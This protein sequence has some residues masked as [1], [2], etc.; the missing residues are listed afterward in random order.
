MSCLQDVSRLVD[1]CRQTVIFR[2]VEGIIACL[3]SI[4]KD[5]DI[6][7]LRIK[8]RLNPEFDARKSAGYRD[9]AL[10]LQIVTEQT[11]ALGIDAHVCELQLMLQSV[12][13]L[14]VSTPLSSLFRCPP[15]TA[16]R[17]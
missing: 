12:A 2:T 14:K 4:A 13:E 15:S 16:L 8:N 5:P 6:K 1:V 17:I 3:A 7:I 11:K 10:N 9:V